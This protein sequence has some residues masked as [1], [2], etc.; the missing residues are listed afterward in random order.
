MP[1][2]SP[3]PAAAAALEADTPPDLA[4]PVV[5][6]RM[7]RGEPPPGVVE[8]EP[9]GGPRLANGGDRYGG[10]DDDDDDGE[11]LMRGDPVSSKGFSFGAR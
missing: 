10:D 9:N 8:R 3:P 4:R 6:G 7:D 5:A 1:L 11:K 2:P